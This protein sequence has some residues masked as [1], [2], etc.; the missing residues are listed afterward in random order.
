MTKVGKG[1]GQ[2]AKGIEQR[3][4]SKGHGAKGK[5]QEN[6]LELLTSNYI[7]LTYLI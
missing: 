6:S 5:G 4:W 2:S 3:A 1:K 7:S